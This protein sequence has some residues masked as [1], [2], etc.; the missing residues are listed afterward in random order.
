MTIVVAAASPDGIVL[1]ADSRTT[2][3]Y[4]GSDRHRITTDSAEKVFDLGS[5]FAVATYRD[6]ST[7]PSDH[8]WRDERVR[9]IRG[10]QVPRG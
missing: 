8:Q 3:T 1:A 7:R 9:R 6:R 2:L 10:R 5:K 4:A